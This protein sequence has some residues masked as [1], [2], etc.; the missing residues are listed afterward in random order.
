MIAGI[1][2][3]VHVN[4]HDASA[5]VTGQRSGSGPFGLYRWS[6]GP[7]IPLLK[8]GQA[9][10]G[11]GTFKDLDLPDDYL[12]ASNDAGQYA[13]GATLTEGGVTR[14]GAYL[15]NPDGTLALILKEGMTTALGTVTHLGTAQLDGVGLNNQGQAAL[16]VQIDK[17]AAEIVLLTPSTP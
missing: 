2:D 11:G 13:F 7:L 5:L 14:H 1:N 17:G 9:L 3:L 8:A 12:V 6:G 10:P 16:S 15:L 4:N